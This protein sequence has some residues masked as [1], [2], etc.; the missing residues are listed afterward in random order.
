MKMDKI[1]LIQCYKC[2]QLSDHLRN[3]CP[4][5]HEPPICS[6]C[7]IIGHKYPDC[8]NYQFCSNCGGG[9][10]VTARCCPTYQYKFEEIKPNLLIDLLTHLPFEDLQNI[11]SS[12]HPSV[13]HKVQSAAKVTC[14]AFSD[15]V[16]RIQPNI[17][18][19]DNQAMNFL[20]C[21]ATSSK[22]PLQFIETLFDSLKPEISENTYSISQSP[23]ESES[24]FSEELLIYPS[25]KNSLQDHYSNTDLPAHELRKT[26]SDSDLHSSYKALPLHVKFPALS[27][28]CVTVPAGYGIGGFSGQTDATDKNYQI[29]IFSSDHSLDEI[30]ILPPG[31]LRTDT[32]FSASIE[33]TTSQPLDTL[34]NI[35]FRCNVLTNSLIESQKADIDSNNNCLTPDPHISFNKRSSPYCKF[36]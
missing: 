18:N 1:K 26:R 27:R 28:S 7:G 3:A 13:L 30:V 21:A 12:L 25:S 9:H 11:I 29:Q 20:A 16:E 6:N 8:E 5:I 2:F 31:L 35:I 17:P 34:E 19:H 4:H 15:P 22:S 10:P 24:R 32:A 36:K 33:S 14:N 23:S